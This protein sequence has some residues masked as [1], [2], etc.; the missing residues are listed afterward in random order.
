MIIIYAL[1]AIA[2]LVDSLNGVISSCISI[3]LIVIRVI[4]KYSKAFNFQ[5]CNFYKNKSNYQSGMNPS[6]KSK[7]YGK[8][9]SQKGYYIS[10]GFN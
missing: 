3:S 5:I 6:D 9:W 7:K 4:N 2:I 1:D 10:Y 8:D